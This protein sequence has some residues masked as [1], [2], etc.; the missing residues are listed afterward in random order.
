VAKSIILNKHYILYN[1]SSI[2]RATACCWVPWLNPAATVFFQ[3][4]S[5][6]LLVVKVGGGYVLGSVRVR[7]DERRLTCGMLWE[8]SKWHFLSGVLM[9]GRASNKSSKNY[10]NKIVCIN[11]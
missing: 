10:Q 2:Y 5:V 6:M 1:K 11:T 3:E 7:Y 4:T 9:A 8:A